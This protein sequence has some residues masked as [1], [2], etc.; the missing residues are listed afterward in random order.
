MSDSKTQLYEVVPKNDYDK[1][2]DKEHYFPNDW[3]YSRGADEWLRPIP[4]PV[5]AWVKASSQFPKENGCYAIRSYP[6]RITYRRLS[7]VSDL[8]DL[9]GRLSGCEW[10]P[11]TKAETYLIELTE[12]FSELMKDGQ[13]DWTD[14]LT[15]QI[16]KYGEQL[17]SESLLSNPGEGD[18]DNV[19][20]GDL[21]KFEDDSN[22]IVR[23]DSLFKQDGI[24]FVQW[25]KIS[26]SGS[27]DNGNSILQDFSFVSST[28]PLSNKPAEPKDGEEIEFYID[29][30]IVEA[31]RQDP[32]TDEWMW[33]KE[34][35]IDEMKTNP[36][37]P[38]RL[39]AS[40]P[41]ERGEEESDRDMDEAAILGAEL[42]Y[43]Q[44]P[45]LPSA[46]DA[47]LLE[48]VWHK[49]WERCNDWHMKGTVASIPLM[50]ADILF[51]TQSTSSG[52]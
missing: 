10:R 41:A 50:R 15:T 32:D 22:D 7:N 9:S 23:V 44:Q 51:L 28:P 30:I 47:G 46:G 26:G 52:K 24:W 33:D 3:I 11:A 48:A 36:P 45:P 5:G 39:E 4:Q 18:M 16:V 20:P 27:F 12:R 38:L 31:R 37:F 17:L 2:K 49:A 35:L 29:N 19:K 8:N 34:E 43:R 13:I 14:N 25:T 6:I 1:F 21:L 40:L 42:Q